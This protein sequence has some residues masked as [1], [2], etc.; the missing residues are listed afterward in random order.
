MEDPY[1]VLGKSAPIFRAIF[2]GVKFP[3]QNRD[4]L[5]NKAGGK[6]R[7]IAVSNSDGTESVYALM[8]LIDAFPQID[9]LFPSRTASSFVKKFAAIE[10]DRRQE[11]KTSPLVKIKGKNISEILKKRPPLFQANEPEI[12]FW[13]LPKQSATGASA[14]KAFTGRQQMRI[15]ERLPRD[16]AEV[17]IDYLEAVFELIAAIERRAALAAAASAEQQANNAENAANTA[18]DATQAVGASTTNEQAQQAVDLA[19]ASADEAADSAQQ[20]ADFAAQAC[21]HAGAIPSDVEAQTACSNARTAASRAQAAA[22]R[23]R[24]ACWR[25]RDIASIGMATICGHVTETDPCCDDDWSGATIVVCNLTYPEI[26]CQTDVTDGNGNYCVTGRFGHSSR[27]GCSTVTVTMNAGASGGD[28]SS[29]KQITV[30]SSSPPSVNFS[31]DA[32]GSE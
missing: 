5:I 28:V 3:I 8:D 32:P 13:G 1:V 26:P 16:I 17:M 12:P 27:V 10:L 15:L 19:C 22:D 23:A 9:E 30:C 31:F 4:D 7:L 2:S 14:I 25:A 20:A 24:G 29:T 18:L 6:E 21:A 11:R